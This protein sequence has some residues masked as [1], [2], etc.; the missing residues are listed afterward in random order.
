M[1]RVRPAL[2]IVLFACAA[3]ASPSR[4]DDVDRSPPPNLAPAT[5]SLSGVLARHF[6]A[7]GRFAPGG[8]PTV[9]E[10]WNVSV[11]SLSGTETFVKSAGDEREDDALGPSQTAHGIWNGRA[12]QMNANGQV[13]YGTGLHAED[14]VD[15]AALESPSHRG[16]TLLGRSASPA[17]FVVEV[18]PPKGRLEYVFF[19]E[20]TSL[21]DRLETVRDARRVTISMD[22]YRTTQGVTRAW[23]LHTT[24]GFATNDED[25]V[26]QSLVLGGS[27]SP[28]EVAVPAPKP[29]LFTVP[30]SPTAVPASFDADRIIVKARMGGHA[31]DFLFDSGSSGIAVDRDLVEALNVKEYGKYTSQ[32]AGTYAESDVILPKITVGP[33]SMERVYASSLPFIAFTSAGTPVAGLLGYDFI[34]NAVWHVDYVNGTLEVLDP[35]TFAPP[36]GARAIDVGFD[37]FVPTAEA[38][39]AGI[40]AGALI[41]DTGADRSTLFSRFAAAHPAL[42]DLG[43]GTAMQAAWPFVDDFSGVGGTVDFRPLQ[44]GPFVFADWSFPKWLFYVTQDAPSFEFEDY[45]GLVGQDL[46]RNFDVYLDYPHAKIYFVPNQRFRQRWGSAPMSVR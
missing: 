37:D 14:A 35:S 32:T 42:T 9:R 44:A 15:Q 41:V 6:A 34:A 5:V 38:T 1:T 33:L 8:P 7:V 22:D 25:D 13:A 12:W 36:A 19:D 24:D 29:P 18:D 45:D 27:V 26:L 31:V 3:L 39:V 23:H 2:A 28:A 4:A 10:R 11:G 46:L 20:K 21:I 30:A 17:A 16:L 40:R 43:L